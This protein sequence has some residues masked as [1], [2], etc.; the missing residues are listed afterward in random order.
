MLDS[1]AAW[2]LHPAVS[3]RPEPFGA[4]LYHFGNRKLSFLKDRTL[5]AV[6]N[7]IGEQPSLDA[8]LDACGVEDTQRPRYLKAIQ[9]LVA[10]EIVVRR[11]AT[12]DAKESA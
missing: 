2:A 6:V 12:S 11:D 10:S 8:A 1:R 5:L 4:L 7:V 3:V 9:T